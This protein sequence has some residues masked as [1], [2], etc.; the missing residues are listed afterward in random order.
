ML[1]SQTTELCSSVVTLL[2]ITVSSLALQMRV[3][4]SVKK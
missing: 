4:S 3:G 1:T 2:C